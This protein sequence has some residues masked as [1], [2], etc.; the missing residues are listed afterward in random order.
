MAISFSKMGANL[1]ICDINMEGLEETKKLIKQKTGSDSNVVT[2]K[3]DV[4]DKESIA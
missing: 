2:F 1:S 3:C 4:S